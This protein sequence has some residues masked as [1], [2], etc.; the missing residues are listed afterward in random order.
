MQTFGRKNQ[1]IAA[2]CCKYRKKI[3]SLRCERLCKY[4]TTDFDSSVLDGISR[5]WAA[6]PDMELKDIDGKTVH[7]ETLVA[8]GKPVIISFF[9]PINFFKNLKTFLHVLTE[10][11]LSF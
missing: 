11:F 2:N 3:V 4:E 10:N 7:T 5:L 6:L 9:A 1:K 8:N